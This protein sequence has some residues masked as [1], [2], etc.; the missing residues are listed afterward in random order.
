M[1]LQSEGSDRC[2]K[3]G[4]ELKFETPVLRFNWLI[5][6]PA[7]CERCVAKTF[8]IE[9]NWKEAVERFLG[10][11]KYPSGTPFGQEPK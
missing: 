8:G 2:Q 5:G 1:R 4:I 10:D 3:C 11:R 7:I 9:A 6:D